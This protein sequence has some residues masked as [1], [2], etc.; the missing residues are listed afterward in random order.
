M[1]DLTRR[2]TLQ[3][4][5]GIPLLAAGLSPQTVVRGV[6]AARRARGSGSP[7]TPVFFTAH[8]YQTVVVL[9][10]YIIPRDGRSGSFCS[11][12]VSR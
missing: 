3:I 11:F 1:S 9:V 5:A 2:D 6:E 8:E 12:P 7:Y 4:L 10:D